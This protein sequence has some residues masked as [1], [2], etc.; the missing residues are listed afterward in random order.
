MMYLS[1]SLICFTITTFTHPLHVSVTEIE[2]DE[3]EKRLEI[4]MRV[5]MDDLE[6]TFRD[7]FKKPELDILKPK[8]STV[9]E[10]MQAYLKSHFKIMLDGKPVVTQ[11]LGHEQEGEAFIFYIEANNVR[12]WATITVQNDIITETHDDQSNLVHV[13]LGE[14]VR[15]LR[16][17]KNNPIDKLTF[18]RK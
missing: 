1:L 7:H 18:E 12:N 3:K 15:S 14:T 8:G 2:M 17:T 16:L 5:F 11:Y 9:D 6:V 13:T 4:M 10:M